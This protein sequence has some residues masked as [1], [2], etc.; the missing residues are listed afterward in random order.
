LGLLRACIVAI[1]ES[2]VRALLHGNPHDA[3]ADPAGGNRTLVISL[4][5]CRKCLLD[6]KSWDFFRSQNWH[7]EAKVDTPDL[8]KKLLPKPISESLA[9]P[10][11]SNMRTT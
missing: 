10:R 8:Q 3:P 5:G 4:E 2:D 9:K 11:A 7:F 1:S 6:Q